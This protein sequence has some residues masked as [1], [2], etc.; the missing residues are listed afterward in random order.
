MSQILSLEDTEARFAISALFADAP[1]VLVEVRF[2]NAGT[3]PDWY[4]CEV[5]EQFDQIL[6]G[7]SPGVELHLNSV[8][9]LR[10]GKGEIGL[11][12]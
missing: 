6:E 10:S 8:W 11:K 3:S 4:L 5:E 7:L 9:A 12:K 1:P 2:P